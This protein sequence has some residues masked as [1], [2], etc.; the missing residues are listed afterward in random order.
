[1]KSSGVQSRA[2]EVVRLLKKYYPDAHC[3]LHFSNPLE[4]LVATILSAQC[5]DARV[6]MVT[7]A[8]FKKFPNAKAYADADPS[9]LEGMVRSTGFYKN[10]A[11]SLKKMGESLVAKHQAEVPANFADLIELPGVGRKT[12]NVVMGNAFHIPSGVV[13]DT[14][15][16][17]LA[18][19]LGLVKEK[20]PDKVAEKLQ[21][22]IPQENWIQFSH[23][24]IQHGREICKARR[25]L[26]EKCFLFDICPKV[27]VSQKI[28]RLGRSL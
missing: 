27:G 10:K 28:R 8:L 11:R 21:S 2:D 5:T 23:W 6:N 1:M 18:I 24:L 19:R 4:L 13:V 25:P 3:A 17:R 20:N 26:C 15:V 9:V 16:G 12:A 7:P 14:H 22:L